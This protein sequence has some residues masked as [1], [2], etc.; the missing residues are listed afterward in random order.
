VS[1]E[2]GEPMVVTVLGPVQA[3]ALGITLPHEH[4]FIDLRAMIGRAPT[5]G[6][7]TL[8]EIHRNLRLADEEVAA[9]ELERFRA[10]GGRSLVEVTTVGIGRDPGALARLARRTG[11]N[12]VMA[13]GFYLAPS[14][15]PGLVRR[16]PQALAEGMVY[17]LLTGVAAEAADAASEAAPARIRAGIIKVGCGYPLA[18]GERTVLDAAAEAQRATG[19]A[20]T[21]HI[22]AHDD[23][24]REILERLTAAGGEPSRT[25]L[26]HLDVCI[27]RV[28]TL[29]E[30]AASGC[31]L[32]FDLFGNEHGDYPGAGLPRVRTD[33]ERV[34]LLR[35]VI[36]RGC[37]DRILVSQDISTRHRLASA[38]GHG[39]GYLPGR[40]TEWS[41]EFG[42]AEAELRTILVDNPAR[43][44]ALAHGGRGEDGS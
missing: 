16:G 24:P 18:P 44:L 4:L 34:A 33:G 35:R 22:G 23:S 9:Y 26:C 13:T 31:F 21:V 28:E 17:E 8:E 14:H 25:I 12:I 43:A 30:L 42:L 40:L 20:V 11:V 39:Y 19:A 15:P 36:D 27:E 32:E 41:E 5:G 37:L 29:D 7:F 3:S 6:R 10:R 2:T 38:G 1:A